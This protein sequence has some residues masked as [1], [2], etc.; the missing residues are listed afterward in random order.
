MSPQRILT[1]PDRVTPAVIAWM[2]VSAAAVSFA[3][4]GGAAYSIVQVSNQAESA[5]KAARA[6]CIRTVRFGPELA[7]AY[8]KYGILSP[9]SR[10][11]YRETIPKS[12]PPE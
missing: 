9:S 4:F 8:E 5:E 12:C 11:A 3:A 7:D 6:S 2:A 10:V 1:F